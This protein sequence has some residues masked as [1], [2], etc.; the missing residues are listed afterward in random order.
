MSLKIVIRAP[1]HLGDCLMALPMISETREAYPGATVTLLISA[2]IACLFENNPA[3][4]NFIKVPPDHL[5]GLLGVMKMKDTLAS[6]NFDMGY[7]LPPSFGSAAGFKLAGIKERIGYISDGRR[8]LLSRPL[9]MP[10]PVGSVHRSKLYFNL[11][12]RGSGKELSYTKPKL[13]I[14]DEDDKLGAGVL[15]GFGIDQNQR[16]AVIAFRA[17][18]ESRRW[19]KANYIDLIK[20][21]IVRYRFKVVLIG[22]D[23][24]QNEGDEIALASGTGKVINLAGKTNL[25]ETAIIL[26]RA[27]LFVGNDSGPAH[28]AAAVGIP[29]VVLS[30]ADDPKVTSP[31]SNSKRVIYLDYLEC[32]SCVKNKCLLKDDNYMRCMRDITTD[33]VVTE[34]ASLLG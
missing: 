4:D 8:M 26:S 28:L 18:A 22:S 2:P 9:P 32:I 10:E 16:F 19:G 29:I 30:G 1:N 27:S 12:R 7:I 33:T 11:L 21:I 6:H 13:F 23:V 15:A 24:E 25:R 17:V 14:G 31:V 5:H 34:I 20:E 3:I